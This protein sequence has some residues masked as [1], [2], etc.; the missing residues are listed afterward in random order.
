MMELANLL[1][2]PYNKSLDWQLVGQSF[3]LGPYTYINL[4][5]PFRYGTKTLALYSISFISTI[6]C[7]QK[8]HFSSCMAEWV[9]PEGT[10]H[11]LG[12]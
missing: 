7:Q 12:F 4:Q 3:N 5:D 1:E 2:L 6:L 8:Y 11:F 10:Q 9:E